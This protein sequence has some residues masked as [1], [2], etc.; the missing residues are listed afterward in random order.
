MPTKRYSKDRSSC[1]VTFALPKESGASSAVVCGDF[2]DWS[3]ESHPLKRGRDGTLKVTVK[4]PTGTSYRYRFLVDG[5]RWENDPSA[6]RHV[7]NPYG[8][9]DSVLE[10]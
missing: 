9:E 2:N 7:V 6:D 10:V 8:S 1:Q 3:E 5:A 4:L